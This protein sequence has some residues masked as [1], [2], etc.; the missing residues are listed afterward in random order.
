MDLLEISQTQ[1]MGR[2]QAAQLLHDIADSLARHN[3]LEFMRDGIK[4]RVIVPSE[5]ELEL[6]VEVETEESSIEIEISW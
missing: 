3:S 6:E 5:V 1:K 2:E 4:L